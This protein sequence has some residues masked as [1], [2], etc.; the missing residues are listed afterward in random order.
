LPARLSPLPFLPSWVLYLSLY[1]LGGTFLSFQWD[2]LLLEAGALAVFLPSPVPLL[3]LLP[4]GVAHA[5]PFKWLTRF[6][7]FKLVRERAAACIVGGAR[8][9]VVTRAQGDDGDRGG[10]VGGWGG[11]MVRVCMCVCVYLM[12]LDVCES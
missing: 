4:S 12:C 9:R 6:L 3:R 11:D 5:P 1:I 7:L 2:I 10:G 8:A